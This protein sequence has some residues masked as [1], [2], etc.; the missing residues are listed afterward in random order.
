MNDEGL[1][2]NSLKKI[3]RALICSI[4]LKRGEYGDHNEY[5]DLA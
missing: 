5:S 2:T 3:T 4:A 1:P